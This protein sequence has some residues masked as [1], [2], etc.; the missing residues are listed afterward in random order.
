MIYHK[1]LKGKLEAI[2]NEKLD[3]YDKLLSALKGRIEYFNEAGCRISDHSLDFVPYAATT[4][5]EA[6]KIYNNKLLGKEI[7]EGDVLKYKTFTLLSVAKEY[8][9]DEET[10]GKIVQDICYNNAVKYFGIEV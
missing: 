10:L 3:K 1:T 8:S 4:Y 9:N 5:E 2:C 7:C 6:A